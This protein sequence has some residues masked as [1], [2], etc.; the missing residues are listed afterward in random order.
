MLYRDEVDEEARNFLIENE[1]MFVKALQNDAD[2]D[3]NDIDDLDAYWHESIV[4]RAYTVADAE[5]ILDNCENEETDSGIWEGLDYRDEMSARAAFS[6]S[7]DVWFACATLYDEIKERMQELIDDENMDADVAAEKAFNEFK[8][9]NDIKV[10]PVEKGSE[11]ELNLIRRWLRANKE[12]AGMRGG[13]P[14]GASYIDSRCGT[15]HGMM[16][17]KEY[18]EFDHLFAQKVPWL[19]GKYKEVVQERHDELV[20]AKRVIKDV[21]YSDIDKM[22]TNTRNLNEIIA[23]KILADGRLRLKDIRGIIENLE[24][25]VW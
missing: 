24:R 20:E 12:D 17:V 16:D 10:A 6:Y 14:V 25:G 2:F 1:E 13:Y 11:D 7:N 9:E 5:Y 3:Y 4:D 23:H 15:G 21:H 8:A 19:S 18:V 22:D